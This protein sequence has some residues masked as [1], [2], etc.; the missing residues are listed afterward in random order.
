MAAF[1]LQ[2]FIAS[3]FVPGLMPV[4]AW[5]P[6]RLALVYA[7]GVAFTAASASLMTGK[8]ARFASILVGILWFLGVLLHL[9]GLIANPR[10][11]AA[12]TT[13]FE[14]L[15]LCG[16][17]LVLAGTL[18]ANL[19]RA[20]ERAT[21]RVI[22]LGLYAFA[23]SVPVFGIQHFIYADYVAA[24]V[25]SWIPGRL[26]WAYFTGVAHI[27]AGVSILTRVKARLAAAMW[28]LMAGLWVVLLHAP[29]V[30]A[31]SGAVLTVSG[32]H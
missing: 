4:P 10:N 32:S 20:W 15:A 23:F 24:V 25:P 22:P 28:A 13:G 27:A 18:P 31:S 3:D 26:F 11:G 2:H 30:V 12:W 14:S 6:G 17:A 5:V 8:G 1:G 29:R 9:P 19:P 16:A 7:T 21:A